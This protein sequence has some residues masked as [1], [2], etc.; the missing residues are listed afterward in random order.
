[1]IKEE[2]RRI[3]QELK[4]PKR[5]YNSFGGYNY[6]SCED[7][8]EAVKPLLNNCVLTITDDIVAVGDR[9]YVKA[10]VKLEDDDGSITTTAYAREPESKKGADQ[11][12]I[13]GASSS[14]A[15]KYALAGLFLL[16]DQKDADST[17]THGNEDKPLTERQRNTFKKW[18]TERGVSIEEIEKRFGEIDNMTHADYGKA[19]VYIKGQ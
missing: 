7:I 11:S 6:R 14:Y 16:D 12:Q 3:Q 8:L 15:R 17:N 1:M 4:A 9:V 5:Q 13:T 2:L 19:L 10:T 18:L